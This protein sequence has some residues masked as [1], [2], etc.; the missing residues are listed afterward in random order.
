MPLIEATDEKGRYY[1]RFAEYVGD[2]IADNIQAQ[3]DPCNGF[4]RSRE[5]AVGR[6][7][8]SIPTSVFRSW[9]AEFERREGP[10]GHGDWVP[11][12]KVFLRAKIDAHPEYRTVDKLLHVTPNASSVIVK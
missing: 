3:K 2:V 1:W 10:K 12:W 11:D 8:A 5:G 7:I 9:Q 4:T 6:K